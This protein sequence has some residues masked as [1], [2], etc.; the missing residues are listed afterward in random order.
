[1]AIRYRS[2]RDIAAGDR[3]AFSNIIWNAEDDFHGLSLACGNEIS[4]SPVGSN[5]AA[6]TLESGRIL[7]LCDA[8]EPYEPKPFFA[9]KMLE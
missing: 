1:M 2:G 4:H 7:P 8:E 3:Q 6:G 9:Q 5:R